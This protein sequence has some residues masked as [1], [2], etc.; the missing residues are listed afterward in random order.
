MNGRIAILLPSLTGGG[1]EKVMLNLSL[2]LVQRH[3][4]VD[5]VLVRAT[6]A[7]L[8]RV[9]ATINLVDLHAAKA[10]M[11]LPSL[12][13]YLRR[14]RPSTV[15]SALECVNLV[16]LWARQLSGVA[17]RCLLT[18]H[19]TVSRDFQKLPPLKR[20]LGIR[21]LRHYY[22][23]AD[24][25]VAVSQGVARDLAGLLGQPEDF[26]SVASNPVVS[27]E[28]YAAAGA[29]VSHPWLKNERQ[30]P[31]VI[32]VG[33]LCAEKDFATLIK[34][35]AQVSRMVECRLVILGEGPL[36]GEL[37]ELIASLGLTGKALLAGFQ[38]NPYAWLARSDLFVLSSRYE[39]LPTVLVEALALGVPVVA[40][41][42]PH[43]PEELL[44]GQL[45]SRLVPVGDCDALARN[46]IMAL[47]AGKE[48]V[49]PDAWLA[50]EFDRAV[51]HYA[52]LLDR[53]LHDAAP[54]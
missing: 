10:V 16:S 13:N 34:A 19:T 29:E 4:P 15:I 37:E 41:R 6:G 42:C 45:A 26:V 43:G 39:G 28:L 3:Y 53:G 44:G 23:R 1:I 2:G 38:D 25:V 52:A 50:Y 17:C 18:T 33:R 46:M 49:S 32:G 14:R 9:P 48:E 30:I 11:A 36:R 35:F 20:Q 40:T 54:H 22:P 47:A 24:M 21:L 31:V 5:L 8:S 12:V 51:D 27:P 7:L